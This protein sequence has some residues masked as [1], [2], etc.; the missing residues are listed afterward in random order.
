MKKIIVN[1]C[2][3]GMVPNKRETPHVPIS[4]A[5]IVE[6]VHEAYELGIT[7]THL[8]ARD[9][10]AIPTYRKSVYR[11]IFESVRKHCPDLVICGSTSGRNFPEF[12]KRSEVIELKPDM[13]SLT[14]SSLNFPKQSSLNAPD[15]IQA[16]VV[17]MNEYGVKP[18]LECFDLGMINYGKYLIKKQLIEGRSYWNLI[19]GNIAGMQAVESHFKLA[20]ADIPQDD[21]VGFGGIGG[22]QLPTF[23]WAIL[24]DVGVRGGL[25]DNIWWNKEKNEL[26][27][28]IQLIKHIHTLIKGEGKE[29]M[30]AKEFGDE[31]FYNTK[32]N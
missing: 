28:N 8:H 24:N 3:T 6:Q 10:N 21:Y 13:C 18:E 5:E 12:E 26:A 17:K 1:F 31:G 25:E 27:T 22:Y 19:F 23:E 7:I 4:V 2:P 14:L 11:N 29:F 20:L 32:R 15:I 30:T 16:L 9:D